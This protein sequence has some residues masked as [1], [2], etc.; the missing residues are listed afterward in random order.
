[1]E[2]ELSTQVVRD[3]IYLIEDG[4]GVSYNGSGIHDSIFTIVFKSY[5]I[6]IAI[7]LAHSEATDSEIA[8]TLIIGHE[9]DS[10]YLEQSD[11]YVSELITILKDKFNID[12]RN[13]LMEFVKD[14]SLYINRVDD[15]KYLSKRL[16]NLIATE[17]FEKAEEVRQRM[18]DNE[19]N[20]HIE[21]N[22][23]D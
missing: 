2:F 10:L 11:P 15:N 5:L 3:I 23:K 14:V 13:H 4:I 9:S 17:Q 1:M 20:S 12:H 22:R 19:K 6:E 21:R 18:V 16:T 8:I 7:D